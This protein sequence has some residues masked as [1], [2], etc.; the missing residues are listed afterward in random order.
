MARIK[1]K[2]SLLIL[3]VALVAVALIIA[4]IYTAN[5]SGAWLSDQQNQDMTAQ[6][7]NFLISADIKFGNSEAA[8][9]TSGLIPVNVVSTTADNYIDNLRV[10]LNYKGESQAYVRVKVLEEWRLADQV[11]GITEVSAV[12]NTPLTAYDLA[13]NW[14]DNRKYDGYFYYKLPLNAATETNIPLITGA[15]GYWRDPEYL[16][17]EDGYPQL[18]MRISVVAEAVQ[19]NRYQQFWH[20]NKLPWQ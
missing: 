3:V 9:D 11:D 6:Y 19:V 10:S 4:V 7:S 8:K 12:P 14:Y 18:T 20:L 5:R 15:S 17:Q 16:P 2:K 13:D 1:D